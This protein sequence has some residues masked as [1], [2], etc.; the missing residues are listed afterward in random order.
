MGDGGEEG[1][2]TVDGVGGDVVELG[3]EGCGEGCDEEEGGEGIHLLSG[4]CG[5]FGLVEFECGWM[6]VDFCLL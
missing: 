3:E 5:L 1:V 2:A 4:M 6:Y